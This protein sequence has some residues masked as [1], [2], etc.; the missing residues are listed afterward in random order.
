MPQR[1]KNVLGIARTI[2]L[3]ID[4]RFLESPKRTRNGQTKT[5]FHL[6]N[7]VQKSLLIG[8]TLRNGEITSGS[9]EVVKHFLPSLLPPGEENLSPKSLQEGRKEAF[10]YSIKG[11]LLPHQKSALH[12]DCDRTRMRPRSAARQMQTGVIGSRLRCTF[13]QGR[14]EVGKLSCRH[15]FLFSS[16]IVL[17]KCRQLRDTTTL[18]SYSTLATR[19]APFPS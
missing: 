1:T 9:R 6:Q 7:C 16:T 15:C 3:K 4:N 11:S 12:C 14:A 18:L 8:T 10:F 17:S 19:G 2:A 13:K 5:R